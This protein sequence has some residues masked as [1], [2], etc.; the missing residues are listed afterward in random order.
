MHE[1]KLLLAEME[2]ATPDVDFEAQRVA[3]NKEIRRRIRASDGF[4]C[5]LKHLSAKIKIKKAKLN[6][7]LT[8]ALNPSLV[9]SFLTQ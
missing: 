4:Y 6:K 8:S 5:K 9:F 2:Q 1:D 7:L 3:G